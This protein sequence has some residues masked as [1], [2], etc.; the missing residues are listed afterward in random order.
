[1]TRREP[2][3]EPEIAPRPPSRMK[4]FLT[5]VLAGGLI[6]AVD[7]ATFG[8][9]GLGLGAMAGG[10]VGWWLSPLLGFQPRRRWLGALLS[11]LYCMTPLTSLFPLASLTAGLAHGLKEPDEEAQ[12]PPAAAASPDVIDVEFKIVPDEADPR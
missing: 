5:A 8:P 7:F 3:Q 6:D 2:F 9:I 12:D 1:M 11:G 10:L 4:R